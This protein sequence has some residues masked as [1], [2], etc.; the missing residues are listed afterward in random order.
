M[1][2]TNKPKCNIN[3]V[4]FFLELMDY[5]ESDEDTGMQTEALA[6]GNSI[7]DSEDVDMGSGNTPLGAAGS[8]EEG[9]SSAS[10]PT[11]GNI[12]IEPPARATAFSEGTNRKRSGYSS[13]SERLS[14]DGPD[15]PPIYLTVR[16]EKE[17]KMVTHNLFGG[18][19]SGAGSTVHGAPVSKIEIIGSF[20]N[21]GDRRHNHI[22]HRFDF[23][24]IRNLS[25]SF[26][27]STLKCTTCQQEHTVLRRE[28][29][30]ND[31]G[32]DIPP[33]FV[34]SDQNFP[35]MIPAGGGRGRYLSE[36][37]SH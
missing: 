13:T 14:E 23:K 30:G 31:V 17:K 4:H 37:Y 20:A 32:L 9:N 11:P 6:T 3:L 36:N 16:K 7:L 18:G 8:S 15:L 26:D 5:P 2:P 12:R 1:R 24:N 19:D 33:V 25:T 10:L 21:A 35:S 28:I 27:M 34:L 29:E 22:S